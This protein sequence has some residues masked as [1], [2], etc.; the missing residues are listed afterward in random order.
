MEPVPIAD[1]DVVQ[2]SRADTC[3]L[4]Y[5]TS[6]VLELSAISR[7]FDPSGTV[8]FTTDDMM[9]QLNESYT[10]AADAQ[11]PIKHPKLTR[12]LM[13][14]DPT[15]KDPTAI[16][17]KVDP[18]IQRAQPM[19]DAP[20]LLPARRPYIDQSIKENRLLAQNGLDQILQQQ[21]R[22]MAGEQIQPF[23]EQS[24]MFPAQDR[25]RPVKIFDV[26]ETADDYESY[27]NLD[28]PNKDPMVLQS[29]YNR[30][31]RSQSSEYGTTE[32]QYLI[33]LFIYFILCFCFRF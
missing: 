21:Q 6:T 14:K 12:K 25:R 7:H 13:N 9:L 20:P 11:T 26:P 23:P 31:V 22:L 4:R 5:N 17:N 33:T 18:P 1:S 28:N 10:P 3:K 30:N 8:L 24:Y 2:Q 32:S 29:Q 19:T 16:N 15:V 27:L